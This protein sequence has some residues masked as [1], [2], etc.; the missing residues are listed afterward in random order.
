MKILVTGVSGFIGGRIVETLAENTRNEIVATGRSQSTKFNTYKNVKYVQQ[1]LS[2]E[3]PDQFY[4]VCIHCAGLADDQSP[5]EQF[6]INNVV[7]TEHLVKSLQ[8]CAT[9]IFMS[10]AS[11]YD[12]ADGEPKHES[13][14]RIN[15]NI[16]DYGKSKLQAEQIVTDSGIA[17]VY[18]LR[19]RA[20][21]GKGDRVLLPRIL[22]LIK[23]NKMILPGKLSNQTSLTHIQNLCEAVT[24]SIIQS[25]QGVNIFN[26][27]DSRIYDLQSIFGEILQAKTGKK[28]F[29]QIPAFVARLFVALNSIFKFK[30]PLSTQSLNYISQNSVLLINKAVEELNYKGALDFYNSIDQLDIE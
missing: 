23:G 14:A 12:F 25:K 9:F 19:P 18:I 20:V 4:D 17:S 15:S 11:V 26:I 21:Y 30:T 22:R 1:D 27:V 2:K 28:K 13:D 3:I 5:P 7:A 29:I 16:S 10:S 6:Y 8:Q 24:N